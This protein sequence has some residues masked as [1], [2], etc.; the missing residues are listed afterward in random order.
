MYRWPR[1]TVGHQVNLHN[2][3]VT[4]TDVDAP[5]FEQ[6]LYFLYTGTS[7]NPVKDNLPLHKAAEQFQ[8]ET[9]ILICRSQQSDGD[10]VYVTTSPSSEETK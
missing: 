2:R 8:V 9:L 3:R 4:I 10:R 5:V 7:K 6:L 1:S